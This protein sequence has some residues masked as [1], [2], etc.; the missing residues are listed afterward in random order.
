M[1]IVSL[2]QDNPF[3][4][5][6]QSERALAVRTGV[7]RHLSEAG[8]VTLP[9]LTLRTGRRAD[10]VALSPKG[11]VMIVEVKSSLA[12]LR[13]DAKWPD[14][15]DFCDRLYFATLPDVPMDEFPAEAGLMIADAYGAE[16]IR[17]CVD[18][19]MPAARRKEV[20]LRFARASAIRLARCC[21]HAGLAAEQF[22][23][24]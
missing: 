16:E 5:G 8:W 17:P 12:D 6:R 15:F 21:A 22:S 23:D 1:P 14:Y 9:E 7:E 13:A 2:A 18:A 11:E 20:H 3:V 4:D 19:K 24:D 10:L